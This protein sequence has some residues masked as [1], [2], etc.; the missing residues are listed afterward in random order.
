MFASLQQTL[1]QID[2]RD[3]HCHDFGRRF[4][5]G[6]LPKLRLHRGGFAPEVEEVV[7]EP[8]QVIG[9]IRTEPGQHFVRDDMTF[10]LQPRPRTAS[11]K[12]TKARKLFTEGLSK[13]EIARQ[14]SISRASVRRLLVR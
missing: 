5:L 3:R 14:L 11:G 8:I 13:S 7:T 6:R 4:R 10:R 12:E 2:F 9:R 1:S